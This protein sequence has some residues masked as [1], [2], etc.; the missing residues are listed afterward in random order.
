LKVRIKDLDKYA[1]TYYRFLAKEPDILGTLKSETFNV[2]SVGNDSA[3]VTI[4]DNDKKVFFEKIYHRPET[5]ELRLYG[6][7]SRDSFN[8]EEDVKKIFR[9]HAV[10]GSDKKHAYNPREM[11]Y[12]WLAPIVSPGYNPDDGVYIGGGV[13]F[14]KQKF[15]KKPYGQLHSVWA[16]YAFSTS[17]YNFGYH[18]QFR[19]LLGD[20]DL[21]LDA[22]VNAPFYTRNFY[23]FGNETAKDFH[24]NYYRVR[25]DEII[26]S[27]SI[28]RQFGTRHTFTTGVEG[29][30]VEIEKSRNRFVTDAKSEIDSSVF[31]RH[32][33]GSVFAGYQFSTL[34]NVVYPRKGVKIVSGVKYVK[35]I[36]DSKGYMNVYYNTAFYFS[37]GK[38][39]AAIRPGIA[40]NI[41][42]NYEFFQANTLGGMKNLRGFRRDRFAGK[43]GLY[44]N[45]EVR[46]KFRNSNGYFL[47]GDF[48]F[49]TFFDNGRVWVPNESSDKWHAGYG[50]GVF[51][52]PYNMMALTATYGMSNEEN[53]VSVKAGFLF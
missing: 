29:W 16:N 15:G 44:N 23:G 1:T 42:D 43:T 49:I 25:S 14:K 45:A 30:S 41:G 31:D 39:T 3:K 22:K 37:T 24:N 4:Q 5:K 13:T 32:Y 48:G 11:R 53:T 21:L 17:A 2:S 33:Y 7:G 18:G 19:E 27:P 34:D 6:M 36:E 38:L 52:I 8:I 40:F 46:L 51:F 12:D 26:L 20:W 28:S 10:P 50:A 35:N 9:V 47:R